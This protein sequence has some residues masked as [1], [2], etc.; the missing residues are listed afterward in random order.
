MAKHRVEKASQ[1]A[2]RVWKPIKE[3]IEKMS[4]GSIHMSEHGSGHKK[5]KKKKR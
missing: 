5:K 3:F 4:K 1:P 2:A